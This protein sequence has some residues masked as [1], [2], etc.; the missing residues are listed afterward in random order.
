MKFLTFIFAIYL[1]K[2]NHGQFWPHSNDACLTCDWP[3]FSTFENAY[4]PNGTYQAGFPPIYRRP[5]ECPVEATKKEIDSACWPNV[6]HPTNCEHKAY[7]C[8]FNNCKF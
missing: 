1:F 7:C 4:L 3:L 5:C 6:D 2:V 8:E